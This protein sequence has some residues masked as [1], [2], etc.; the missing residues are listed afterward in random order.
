M[1]RFLVALSML[2]SSPALAQAVTAPLITGAGPAVVLTNPSSTATPAGIVTFGQVFAPGAVP[3]G[4]GI[5]AS[6]P[7]AMDVKARHPDGSVRHGIV[8][9]KVPALAPHAKQVVSLAAGDAAP[10]PA[11]IKAADILPQGYALTL[12]L[13]FGAGEVPQRFDIA[14][15]VAA[16]LEKGTAKAWLNDALVKEVRVSTPVNAQMT[17]TFDVRAT[18]D[19]Q[20]MTD[21]I[22]ANDQAFAPAMDFIYGATVADQGKV[23]FEEKSISHY[24]YSNWHKQ[25]WTGTAHPAVIVAV[26]PEYMAKAGAIAEY[27]FSLGVD[28]KTLA[29]MAALQRKANVGPVK[30]SLIT[31]WMETTG[32]RSDIG[33]TTG[34][35][36]NYLIS[37]DPTARAVM[38]TQADH[39]G[40][41]PWHIRDKETNLP[42]SIDRHPTAWA[43]GR[44]G[45]D[46]VAADRFAVPFEPKGAL[47]QYNWF[48]DTAHEPD[49]SFIPYLVTG[50]HYYLD[51]LESQAAYILVSG[52]PVYRKLG[53]GLFYTVNQVRGVAWNLRDIANAGWIA[54]EGDPLKPTFDS[55]LASNLGGMAAYIEKLHASGVEGQIEG[56]WPDVAFGSN[57]VAPWQNDFLALVLQQEARRGVAKAEGIAAWLGKFNAGRFTH[58]A[59]GFNPLNGPGYWLTIAGTS[60]DTGLAPN[61]WAQF[62]SHNF[63]SQPVPTVLQN[64]PDCSFCY[65]ANALAALAGE[66]AMTRSPAA[67]WAYAFL[68]AN[69]PILQAR[70]FA[71]DPSWHLTPVLPD[72]YHLRTADIHLVSD[73][74]GTV[75]AGGAHSLLAGGKGNNVLNGGSGI[76]ILYAGSGKSVMNVGSG[77]TYVVAGAGE[78]SKGSTIVVNAAASGEETIMDFAPGPGKLE[79]RN[80]HGAPSVSADPAGNMVLTVGTSHKITLL[81]VKSTAPTAGWLKQ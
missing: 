32:G 77:T 73:E 52:N 22:V 23:L 4:H 43:D 16:A 38:L 7:V 28:A 74:G 62:Y 34:W 71:A 49:L 2:A 70:G 44:V 76:T 81:G 5:T 65:G 25:F 26:D 1:H 17:A 51:E 37:Q 60:N 58:G 50:D 30:P 46:T 53:E 57:K 55:R 35:A 64:F 67:I 29:D 54:P 13:A 48:I 24:A 8:S 6:L 72:G 61:S 63:G 18:A 14:K 21:V 36:A 69:T 33:L 66:I 3:K 40:S 10:E 11:A 41:V 42:V 56:Y 27:D 20:I 59:E 78:G 79:I 15:L 19:G 12:T 39:A 45:G 31:T 80:A 9:I 47:K 75:A 68:V